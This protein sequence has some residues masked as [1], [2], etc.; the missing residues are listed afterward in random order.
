MSLYDQTEN[1]RKGVSSLVL[2]IAAALLTLL[3]YVHKFNIIRGFG[4]QWFGY[5]CWPAMLL[6]AFL[7]AEGM[8]RTQDRWLYYVRILLFACLS[9]IPYDRLNYSVNVS[10]RG[11]NPLFTILLCFCVLYAINDVRTRTDNMAATIIAEVVFTS[12]GCRL[13]TFLN[14]ELANF[15]VISSVLCYISVRVTYSGWFRLVSFATLCSALQEENMTFALTLAEKTLTLPVQAAALPALLLIHFYTGRRG[16]NSL[17]VRY[18]S[19][20]FYPLL[21][22]AAMIIK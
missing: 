8:L 4:V 18:A 11:Q 13:G 10:T 15:A 2:R 20:L 1:E 16:P 9:E 22:L 12:L 17:P 14:L 6:Y 7:L 21:L 3:Y 19:Y 5:L